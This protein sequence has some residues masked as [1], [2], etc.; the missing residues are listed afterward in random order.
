MSDLGQI[1][2]A[3]QVAYKVLSARL[4][5][6]LALMMSFGLFCWAM[7][8]ATWLHFTVAAVF[9]VTIFLPVLWGTRGNSGDSH[10]EAS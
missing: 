4:L 2:A 10:D 5:A 6:L 7:A 9:G 1:F 8:Y 3:I